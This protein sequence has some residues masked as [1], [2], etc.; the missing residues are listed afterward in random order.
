MGAN[1]L[2][3]R[4]CLGGGLKFNGD[5][6]YALVVGWKLFLDEVPGVRRLSVWGEEEETSRNNVRFIQ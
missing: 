2:P 3:G 5:T 6:R 1:V 4:G